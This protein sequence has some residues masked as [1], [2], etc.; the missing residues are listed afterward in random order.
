MNLL[1]QNIAILRRICPRRFTWRRSGFRLEAIRTR[2]TDDHR[3]AYAYRLFD[4]ETLLFAGDQFC[5]PGLVGQSTGT[6]A[7][8]REFLITQLLGFLSLQPGDTD[9]EYFADYTPAQLAW[10][11][12]IRG[13]E[14]AVLVSDREENRTRQVV[15]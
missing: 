4:G 10:V 8:M 12:G 15:W 14:L 9:D 5:T 7:R 6:T 13:Q 1:A 2:W 11:T 3:W